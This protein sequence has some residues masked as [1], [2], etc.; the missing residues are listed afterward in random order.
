MLGVEIQAARLTPTHSD[1]AQRNPAL[2]ERHDDNTT[3]F[4][5]EG[6]SYIVDNVLQPLG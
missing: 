1:A 5:A 3:R 4:R 6:D 2:L